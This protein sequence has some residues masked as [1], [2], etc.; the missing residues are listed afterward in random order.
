MPPRKVPRVQDLSLDEKIG[1]LF[2]IAV[3]GVFQNETSPAWI[4]ARKLIE[5]QHAGTV[6]L[7]VSNVYESA[8]LI[9][10]MQA[11]ARVPL[12]I[13]ADLEAG[14]GM[15]FNDTTYWPWAMAVGATGDPS[16]AEREGAM[17]ARQAKAIGVNQIYAPVCDLNVDPDNPVINVRS[18][19]EDPEEV[20]KYVAAFIRGVHSE[21]VLTT[22]KHFPGH[23][24]THTD[25]HRALPVLE[26]SRERL[27]KVELLPF[28]A[29]LAAGTD[30]VMIGHLA[31]PA[32]DPAPVP[33]LPENL[34]N[35]LYVRGASEAPE[36]G[37]LP[38][39][40]SKPMIDGLLRGELGFHGI[41][42][43]DAMDMGGIT[44]HFTVGEAAVRAIEAGEDQI[45]ISSDTPAAIA[46]VKAAVA[47][48]RLS[49]ARIDASVQRI[50]EAKSRVSMMPSGDDEI[51][52]VVDSEESRTVAADIA[53]RCITLVREERGA[54]PIAK[55]ARV[56][57]VSV[58]ELP[59]GVSPLADF[60]REM[61]LRLKTPPKTFLLE[62]R[63]TEKDIPP[64]VEAARNADVV[65]FAL[66]VRTSSGSGK[67]A[68]PAVVRAAIDAVDRLPV[69]RIGISFGSP[70]LIREVPSLKTYLCA[71]GIQ[72]VVQLAATRVLFGEAP[73]TGHLPVTIPG[74][75]ARGFGIEKK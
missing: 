75:Y 2:G 35:N 15:R 3:Y 73:V 48:G 20:S 49:E 72:P 53:R 22:A 31:V 62:A 14:T 30:S 29:A 46:G 64:I 10:R 67:I 59:E 61:R 33:R 38:A 57:I 24:D 60:E 21:G 7:Y 55:D 66:G 43:T 19:G 25:S 70:Y 58:S 11:A 45:L 1:Q 47:S 6:M 65:V 40:L 68:V 74:M 54:L 23:G 50:L 28:R 32:L 4:R 5:E 41:V 9:R 8:H 52:R 42:V 13:S 26:V 37:T 56:V 27:E 36:A 17:V 51:F 71:Y 34:R 39:T 69:R 12:L 44:D 18:F 63:A 16:L